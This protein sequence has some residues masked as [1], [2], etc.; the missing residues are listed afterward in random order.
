MEHKT[1]I[2]DTKLRVETIVHP[3]VTGK[4][5]YYIKVGDHLI[6]VG[7]KTLTAVANEIQ[8]EKDIQSQKKEEIKTNPKK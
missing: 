8:K 3:S 5:M 1:R 6:N 2:M 7:I 4:E